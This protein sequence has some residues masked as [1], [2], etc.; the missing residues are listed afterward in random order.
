MPTKLEWDQGLEELI[1][2]QTLFAP[3]M[4]R[5]IARRSVKSQAE[6]NTRNRGSDKVEMEDVIRSFIAVTPKK[7]QAEMRKKLKA[8][9]INVEGY[10]RSASTKSR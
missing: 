1:N 7:Y 3:K 8:K 4:F 5:S 9:G 10:E 2:E 6:S